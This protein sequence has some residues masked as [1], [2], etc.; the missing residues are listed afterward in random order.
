M[1][2]QRSGVLENF[3][4]NDR[5]LTLAEQRATTDFDTFLQRLAEKRDKDIAQLRSD[6]YSG[7]QGV[8]SDLAGVAADRAQ[9]LGLDPIAAQQPYLDKFDDLQGKI[10][11]L[12]EGF[13][14]PVDMKPV[15][16]NTPSLRDFVVDRGAVNTQRQSG[17]AESSPYSL[18]LKK[19]FQ[20]S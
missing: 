2:D 20:E 11:E 10:R 4:E 8:Y 15:E 5:D 3:G 1:N 14:S 16:V 18:F 7:K 17:G 12:P 6:Q 13:L 19:R 9:L